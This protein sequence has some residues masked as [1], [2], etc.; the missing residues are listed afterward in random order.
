MKYNSQVCFAGFVNCRPVL[1]CRHRAELRAERFFKFPFCA[2]ISLMLKYIKKFGAGA[3]VGIA[4]VIPGVSG[5]TIAVIFGVYPDLISLVSADIKKIK[6]NKIG[7]LFLIGGVGA[8]A[9]LF[10]RFFKLLYQ[11]FPVQ[12]NFFFTGLILGS[13][14]V[15]AEFLKEPQPSKKSAFAFK[16]VWFSAGLA[17][18]LILYFAQKRFGSPNTAGEVI[19]ILSAKSAVVLFFA[20]FAGAAAM[21]I[22][23][24]SGSFVLLMLGVYPSVI[25]AVTDFNIPILAVTGTGVLAGLAV[26]GKIMSRLL[27]EHEKTVYAFISGLIAG[28]VLYV[29]PQ[30]C[31]PFKMRIVS[32]CCMFAGYMLITAFERNKA[33]RRAALEADD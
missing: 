24:I 7:L 29:F 13:L 3:A 31:Q 27:Q 15:L 28:S 4:N 18:M 5:G 32:A 16:C 22:P 11:K 30:V 17:L 14:F 2:I 23:G 12:T 8:G 20:G 25:R 19:S 21:I 9:V 33:G 26:S 6:Q 10:A 1:K